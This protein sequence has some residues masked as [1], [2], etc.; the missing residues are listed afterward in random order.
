MRDD[1][2]RNWD[3]PLETVSTAGL[4][5]S[6]QQ[7]PI[8]V[9][10]SGVGGLTVLTELRRQL[11]NESFIYF[12]DTAHVPYGNRSRSDI[13]E[14]VRQILTW[15]VSKSVKMV[16][17]ACNTSSALAL[18]QVRSE[19]E[20]LMLGIVLPGAR[21]AVHHGQRIGVIAT[22]A[23]VASNSYQQAIQEINP[24]V[25][26]HQA[27][28]PEFVPLVEQNRIYD[29]V[30]GGIDLDTREKVRQRLQPLLDQGIDTLVYGCTHYPHLAPVVRELLPRS[31]QEVD[32]AQH[33]AIAVAQ[34]LEILQLQTPK[35]SG[36]TT[37]FVSGDSPEQFAEAAQQWL[38]FRPQVQSVQLSPLSAVPAELK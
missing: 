31:V 7:L 2:R 21:A 22:P 27:A 34:E 17:M 9:F 38:G 10:D 14:I 6:K 36:T 25:Q 13:L 26:V 5:C 12:G 8:G 1:G 37:F 23:T 15:M 3:Y 33:M 16:I 20:P 30:R 35:R 32:P 4:S 29:L 18:D 19:F 28:C 11:P 24:N